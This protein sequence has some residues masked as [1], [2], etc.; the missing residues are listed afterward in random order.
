VKNTRREKEGEEGEEG[1]KRIVPWQDRH[2]ERAQQQMKSDA[3]GLLG[4]SIYPSLLSLILSLSL[5]LFL[6]LYRVFQK[7]FKF[8]EDI[9]WE[10]LGRLK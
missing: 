5:S 3:S 6:Y 1:E 8:C 9:S 7:Y 10:P 2:G 4:R